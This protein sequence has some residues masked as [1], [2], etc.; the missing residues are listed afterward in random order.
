[1]FHVFVTTHAPTNVLQD[2]VD[3]QSGELLEGE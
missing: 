1:M 3:S 2:D